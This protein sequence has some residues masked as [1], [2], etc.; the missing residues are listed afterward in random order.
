MKVLEDHVG[1]RIISTLKDLSI[2]NY[3]DYFKDTLDQIPLK[4]M[5]KFGTFKGKNGYQ[6]PAIDHFLS[7]DINDS[8]NFIQ[9]FFELVNSHNIRHE[10]YANRFQRIRPASNS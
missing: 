5:S 2:D 4:W 3:G 8:L 9:M 10:F 1:Y 7:C 6:H